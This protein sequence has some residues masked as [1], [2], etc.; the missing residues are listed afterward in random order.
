ML[1]RLIPNLETRG[2]S[3][4]VVS[5]TR[6]G[7]VGQDLQRRGVA[8]EALGLARGRPDP[9]GV[10][11]LRRLISAVQPAVVQTWMYHA[12]LLGAL[13][14]M[15][16][17]RFTL[18]WNLRASHLEMSEYPL[19]S[20]LTRRGCVAL[21]RVPA[22]VLANSTAGRDYHEALGYR[23]RRWLVLPNGIDT[24]RFRPDASI[25]DQARREL[26]LS[27][28]ELPLLV[29]FVAR[30]DPMKGHGVFLQAFEDL[31][32][33][34][35]HVHAL[36]LGEGALAETPVFAHWL[37]S[38]PSLRSRVHFLG[39]RDDVERWMAALDVFCQASLGEGFPNAIAEAM[40]AG[41]PVV[42]TD[43]G[44]TR[45]VTDDLALLVPPRQD[46]PLTEALEQMI[47]SPAHERRA[48]GI[49]GRKRIV[50]HYSIEDVS[51]RY[52][53]LYEQLVSESAGCT[54]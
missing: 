39:R 45:V 30:V 26:G 15:A 28:D 7:V 48:R 18:A 35:P 21:S 37:E 10:W 53:A 46:R 29:G 44:D 2:V 51:A 12:D 22:L 9:R 34:H 20:R 36:F 8:V 25:R 40:A 19:L 41:V 32:R 42:A 54:G 13:V 6:V 16:G 14:R 23:P 1:S 27:G 38:R 43:V 33:R 31:V 3:N 24:N 52:A 49:S 50:Q 5:M 4:L 17:V 47:A 11:R